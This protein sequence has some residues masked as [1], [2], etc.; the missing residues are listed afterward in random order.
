MKKAKTSSGITKQ[1]MAIGLSGLESKVIHRI[2]VKIERATSEL[3][4]Y[5]DVKT[6]E[7]NDYIDLKNELLLSDFRDIFADRTAQH[8]DK[9]ANHDH[10]LKRVEHKVGLF[11]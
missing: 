9:L 4:E 5:I 7:T 10:R 11:L 6:Q 3:K 1:Q 8:D 2:D